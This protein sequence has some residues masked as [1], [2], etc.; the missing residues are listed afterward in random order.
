MHDMQ[1]YN[2]VWGRGEAKGREEFLSLTFS[3]L[4]I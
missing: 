4:A 1:I 3:Y 2:A